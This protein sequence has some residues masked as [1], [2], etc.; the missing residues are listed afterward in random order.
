[1]A[2][3]PIRPEADPQW[4]RLHRAADLDRAAMTRIVLA[5]LTVLAGNMAQARRML[6]WFDVE[7]TI[8]ALKLEQ[9]AALATAVEPILRA[10]WERGLAVAAAAP[11]ISGTATD[12][13]VRLAT[14][15]G[16]NIDRIDWARRRAGELIQGVSQETRYA[17]RRIVE[18]AVARGTAP[19]ETGKLLESVVGLTDRQAQAVAR[20][21]ETLIAEGVKPA[22]VD[23]MTARYGAR[24]LRLRAQNIALTETIRAANEGRR[25][26]WSRNVQEGTILPDRWER[27]WVAIVPSDGRTC[28]YC[29]GQDGQRAP[30]DGTYPNGDSGPPGHTRCRCTESLV[31]VAEVR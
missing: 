20:Y 6:Q 15:E 29:I 19:R 12:L 16:L 17:V 31:R 7:R 13:L 4:V 14:N 30:I 10:T 28:R 18:T 8:A 24:L 22:T 2:D 1:V 26:V 3:V 23:R 5:Y 21:R 11:P 25:A 27:E 9:L